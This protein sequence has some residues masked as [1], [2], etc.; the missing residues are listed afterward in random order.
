[1]LITKLK[2]FFRKKNCNNFLVDDNFEKKFLSVKDRS[3]FFGY[4]DKSPF[5]YTSSKILACVTLNNKITNESECTKLDIGFYD[6]TSEDPIFNHITETN[7]WSWQQ[8]CML[9]WVNKNKDTDEIIYNKLIDGE[10]KAEIYNLKDANTSKVLC[11]SIYSIDNEGKKATSVNFSRIHSFRPGYGY[12]ILPFEFLND[13]EYLEKDGLFYIDIETNQ[14]SLLVSFLEL[15]SFFGL[16]LV[17]HIDEYINHSTFSPDGLTIAFFYVTNIDG[18]RKTYFLI[19]YFTDRT[20]KLIEGKYNVS[21]YCWLNNDL[22]IATIVNKYGFI[23]YKKINLM[24]LKFYKINGSVNLDGHPVLLSKNKGLILT[25]T[26]PD[27]NNYQNLY[28]IDESKGKNF[29]IDRLLAPN[30]FRGQIRCDL[31]PRINNSEDQ[32]SI[33]TIKDGVRVM[34]VYKKI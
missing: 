2:R 6:M 26:Y 22:I 7:I 15:R 1:M 31:H 33:D 30:E 28:Y 13:L 34:I 27:N 12:K 32:I 16:S 4:H 3:V 24:N 9:Q 11:A 21:H 23:E 5:N 17:N 19:Y 8:G 20:F 25:D 29:L 18:I 14:K 10:Y